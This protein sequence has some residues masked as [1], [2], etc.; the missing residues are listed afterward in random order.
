MRPLPLLLVVSLP[1]VAAGCDPCVGYTGTTFLDEGGVLEPGVLTDLEATYEAFVAATG[2]GRVCI[3]RVESVA[4]ANPAGS[5][6]HGGP[7]WVIEID[8]DVMFQSKNLRGHL[9]LALDLREGLDAQGTELFGEGG[10]AAA[11]GCTYP[12]FAWHEQVVAACGVSP[13]SEEDQFMAELVFPVAAE[14]RVDGPLVVSVGAPIRLTGLVAGGYVR[15]QAPLGDGLLLHLAADTGPHEERVLYVD[16]EAG[17]A[18]DVFALAG[19]LALSGGADAA[20]VRAYAWESGETS[21]HV[22]DPATRVVTPLLAAPQSLFQSVGAV[23]EGALY[24]AP[25]PFYGGTAI[26]AADL[27]TGVVTE[28]AL[29][30]VVAPLEVLPGAIVPVPGGFVLAYSEVTIAGD[31][32]VTITVGD[33]VLARWSAADAEWTPLTRGIQLA[34]AGATADGRL[35]GTLY[36]AGDL[37]GAYAYDDDHLAVS[38]DLCLAETGRPAVVAGGRAWRVETDGAD[39]VLTP[40]LLE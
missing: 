32:G 13:L 28:I 2:P 7:D 27:E 19:N 3:D 39:V 8:P 31:G 18:T 10:F 25:S 14:G 30:A 1:A 6:V 40:F 37:F 35:V 34:P 21:F 17:V 33:P 26:E 4:E 20:V 22:I 11:C 9:C 5:L 29:P 15:G 16:L 23:S 24:L 36:G 12:D 38:V